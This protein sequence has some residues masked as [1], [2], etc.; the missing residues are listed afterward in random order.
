[1]EVLLG[2]KIVLRKFT[3]KSGKR[4]AR[5]E[6]PGEVVSFAGLIRRPTR[7]SR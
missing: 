4:E 1:M 2:I 5:E 3:L 6:A 7:I